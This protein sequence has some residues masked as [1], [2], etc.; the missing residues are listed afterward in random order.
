MV[1]CGQ[2]L[3]EPYSDHIVIHRVT[4]KCDVN[5]YSKICKGKVLSGPILQYWPFGDKWISL[6]CFCDKVTI[7]CFKDF[8]SNIKFSTKNGKFTHPSTKYLCNM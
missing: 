8:Q 3:F 6:D 2:P 1:F 4:S 7:D 5:M